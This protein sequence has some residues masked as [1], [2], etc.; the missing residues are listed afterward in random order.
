MRMTPHERLQQQWRR[1]DR[2]VTAVLLVAAL[3]LAALCVMACRALATFAVW[4]LLQTFA[5][6]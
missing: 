1:V 4:K 5:G 2:Q 6:H 3:M